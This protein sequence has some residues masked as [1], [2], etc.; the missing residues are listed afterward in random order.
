MNFDFVTDLFLWLAELATYAEPW[1][2]I[3]VLLLAGAIPFIESYL[4]SFLG[5]VLGINP[6]LAVGSAIVGNM[7]STFALIATAGRARSAITR[8]NRTT[9]D[10]AA[11]TTTAALKEEDR[12]RRQQKVA[13]YAN[14]I[15]VPGVCLLGPLLVASQITA[16]TLVALGAAKRSVYLWQA[17]AIIAWGMLFG[18]FGE[19]VVRFL[20]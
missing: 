11:G 3:G 13:Q 18:F 19:A 16:P 7:I 9:H 1:Q 10:A 5:V 20:F 8:K 15:G 6:F 2:Q 12:T 14:R 4:G 17:I